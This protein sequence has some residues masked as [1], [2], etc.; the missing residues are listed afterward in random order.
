LKLKIFTGFIP[1]RWYNPNQLFAALSP[2][3]F[4][5]NVGIVEQKHKPS[6]PNQIIFWLEQNLSNLSNKILVEEIIINN[7]VKKLEGKNLADELPT[8]ILI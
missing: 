2:N 8:C 7:N 4:G 6:S 5:A 1:G 3:I